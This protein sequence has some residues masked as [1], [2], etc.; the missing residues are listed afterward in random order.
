MGVDE[1][2]TLA[3]LTACRCEL[4]DPQ[5]AEHGGRL[6]KTTGDG[7]VRRIC[8]SAVDAVRCATQIQR[9]MSERNTTIQEDRRIE[10]R[11]GINFGDIIIYEGDI[12]GD[13]VNIAARVETLANPGGV[14]LSDNAYQQMKGK[15][16]LDVNDMGK[17]QLKISGRADPRL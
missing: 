8:L 4:I 14:C 12:Y 13:G 3:A 2:G 10:F 16:A 7:C 9:A 17:H 11:I 5:F 1:E 15:L 6:V